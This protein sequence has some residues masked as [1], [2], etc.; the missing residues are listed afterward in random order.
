MSRPLNVIGQK[1]GRLTVVGDPFMKQKGN[2]SS[3]HYPCLCECGKEVEVA[4]TRLLSALV[5]S[6]G[7]LRLERQRSAVRVHGAEAFDASEKQKRIHKSW[8]SMLERCFNP[9]AIGFKDYGGRGIQVCAQ[10][11]F[12]QL[13]WRDMESTWRPGLSI[14]RIDNDGHY[15]RQNCR[16]ATDTEQANN[17]RRCRKVRLKNHPELFAATT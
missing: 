3:A 9:N 15:N 5:Q 2:R 13:F 7:C 6:C 16:W 14:D 17:T 10:W 4:R 1:F 12:F 8:E 11:T